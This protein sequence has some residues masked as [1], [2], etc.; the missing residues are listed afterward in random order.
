[1]LPTKHP[2]GTFCSGWNGILQGSAWPKAMRPARRAGRRSTWL[3]PLSEVDGYGDRIVVC[4]G[5][6]SLAGGDAAEYR[7]GLRGAGA[8]LVGN[9][10]AAGSV[11]PHGSA[12]RVRVQ[13]IVYR[14][15]ATAHLT[16]R[17]GRPLT[18]ARIQRDRVRRGVR[19]V[20]V[21]VVCASTLELIGVGIVVPKL[22]AAA[23]TV[24]VATTVPDTPNVVVAVPAH[25]GAHAANKP[26][27]ISDF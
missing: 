6:R 16:R 15:G 3:S 27:A 26:Q 19:A 18:V 21:T 5:R 9:T 13:R 4:P 14:V 22:R 11:T 17:K 1:M 12:A 8:G 23:D 25:T 20:A 2:L 7:D 24:Q 10:A